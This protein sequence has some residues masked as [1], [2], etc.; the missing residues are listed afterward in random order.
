MQ[1]SNTMCNVSFVLL[2]GD[3]NSFRE[4]LLEGVRHLLTCHLLVIRLHD[5][6]VV[7][8]YQHWDYEC[9]T[10]NSTICFGFATSKFS[11]P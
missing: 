2:C 4:W 9:N 11:S 6:L 1:P 7:R 5:D 10:S 3:L 8:K